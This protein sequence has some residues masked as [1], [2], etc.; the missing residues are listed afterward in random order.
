MYIIIY[1]YNKHIYNMYTGAYPDI[2]LSYETITHK[3]IPSSYDICFA[4][5]QAKKYIVWYSKSEGKNICLLLELNR[6][7]KISFCSIIKTSNIVSDIYTG[8]ILFGSINTDT[9]NHSLFIVEDILM[10]Q[11]SSLRNVVF[12]VK[13]GLIEFFLEKQGASS[14]NKNDD[15]IQ[16]TIL[17]FFLPV[18]WKSHLGQEINAIPSGDILYPLHHIQY[19]SLTTIV[20]YLNVFINN[21]GILPWDEYDCNIENKIIQKNEFAT[22]LIKTK[23]NYYTNNNH[24]NLGK[25][26]FIVIADS[27]N[28]IY[29]L[30]ASSDIHTPIYYDIAYIPN[31]KNSVYMNSL[32]RNVKENINLDF[33]EE[34]DDEDDFEDV[35]ENKYV[36]LEKKIFMECV[37]HTKFKRWVPI[38]VIYDNNEDM[39]LVVNI[40]NLAN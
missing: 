40:K 22:R 5:P 27:Q 39:N 8:T 4:I 23:K 31:Y 26:T 10:F 15:Q 35:R 36:D 6:Y 11:G 14:I 29:H 9:E 1:K 3:K 37:Y 2:E 20:P 38:K 25:C 34:S 16:N 7:K 32:F 12:G 24:Y 33:I 18:F 13:L 28:D 19:R 21:R 30:F 17:T